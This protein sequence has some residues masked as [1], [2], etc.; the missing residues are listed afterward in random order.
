[1]SL[2][3]KLFDTTAEYNA[4]TADT[5]NFILPN[6]SCTLDDLTNV[7]YN[8]IIS[9]ENAVIT[10]DSATYNAQT[11]VATN[12]VVTLNGS[13][14]ASGIDYIVSN[15]DGGINVGNYTFTIDGI[16]NYG[17][18]KNGTF[19]INKI[20]PTVTAPT[21]KVL[22]YNGSAQE[23][24]NAGSTNWGTLQYRAGSDSWST[25]I[26]TRTRGGSYAVEYK[27]VG[28]SNINDVAAQSVN[29]SINEKPVTATVTLSQTTYTYDN[30]AKKPTPTVKDGST[31]IDPSEY[32]VAYSNNVNAGTGTVTISDNTGGD[33][34]VIGSATFTI[35]KVTPTVTA[36]TAKSL[37]YNGSAQ[38]LVN[39]GSTN[40]GTLKYSL[41]NSTYSTGIP[42]GTNA[43]SYTVYYKVDGDSNINSVAAQS[44]A[45]TITKADQT[46]PTAT[47]ASVT[48]GNTATATASG[49]GGK[50]TIEWNNGDTLTGNVGSK[51]TK[52]RW[53]GNDNYNA[54][55]YSNE[56]TL[57]IT[58]ANGSVTTAPTAKSLT[59]SGSAQALVNAGSGT[60][61]MMYKL[62]IGAWGTSIPNG[63]NA[64]SYTVY[65]KASASTNYNES[66][67][68]SVACSIAK[69][70][71]TYTAPTAKSLTYTGS[72]QALLNAGSTSHGTIQYS[73]NNSSWSTTIPSQTNAGSYT[74]YWRLVGD[75]NHNDVASTSISTTIAKAS[76]SAPTATGATTTYPTTATATA[77]GGGGQGSLEWE[78]AKSQSSVGSHATRARWSGNSNYNAS[79]WSNEVTLEVKETRVVAK[80]NVTD[81]SS[82]TII[83]YGA[84]SAFSAIEIDGVEQQSVESAYTFNTTGEHTVK[85]TL[86]DP[87]IIGKYTFSAAEKLVSVIIPDSVT[88]IGSNVFNQH[89]NPL[90]VTMG[91]GVTTISSEAFQFCE[92][93]TSINIPSSVTSIGYSAFEECIGLTSI[94]IPDS[95]TSI[96]FR[97]FYG[98]TSLISCTI[99][100]GVTSI[101]NND[102]NGCSS[103]RSID[104]PN[105][106]T[107][108][109]KTA[110]C[111]CRSLTNIS[112]PSSVTSISDETPFYGCS[113][114]TSITSNATTAPTIGKNTF[115]GVVTNGTLYVP[116]GS[117]G[118]DTW[119]Q[120]ANY[121]LGLYNWT[122]VEQ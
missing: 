109:G 67:S 6:V 33:Y 104:I 12:I 110:F 119:M 15:N 8:P 74:S 87:T 24:V 118:Y 20:T 68:G 27:V 28:D 45:V 122:K 114:L 58:K 46:A 2:F 98:C 18:S 99:G 49:G 52:A 105:S 40:W 89:R 82:P 14:L 10:C 95:V 37:T 102:F 77:N 43:T 42:S 111:G 71:P 97:A 76:Q 41:D 69:A 106:V 61:T 55:P 84:S 91:S 11:Q 44:V 83:G 116:Q 92:G 57:S 32:S 94:V 13:T 88:T 65:Y 25:S 108:I 112:I 4:Y 56:V 80:Y 17:G 113:G 75:A 30:T 117:T 72:A 22:T 79:P 9:I 31:I 39:A 103:L 26:P 101:G 70:T 60:G 23:L 19:T 64:T 100:S 93:L 73:S 107:S 85:C 90:I 86:A 3:L 36:P 16:G 66:A 47:G 63:T 120:N 62:D 35:N 48:Y 115:L 29:C 34:N 7:Y 81:T 121:Y 59:Y 54:S 53:S 78:S 50:G 5:E 51:T 96:G 1:M 21:A 38:A